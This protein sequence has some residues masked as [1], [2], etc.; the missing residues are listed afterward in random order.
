MNTIYRQHSQ[1]YCHD[2]DQE[3]QLLDVDM[4]GRPCGKKAAFAKQRNRRGRQVGYV[5]ATKY[6]EI[7]VERLF[8]GKT[9]LTRAL[10]PL[11]NDFLVLPG[12]T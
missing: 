10:Q 7:V 4:T 9:Q 5:L 1:G 11:V 12:W 3:W 2:Y 6:E 8:D